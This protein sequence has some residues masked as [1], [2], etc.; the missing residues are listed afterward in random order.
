MKVLCV[1]DSH[2]S[3][4]SGFDAIQ[5]I[6]PLRSNN[7]YLQFETIHLGPILAYSLNKLSSK[8]LGREKLFQLIEERSSSENAILFCFGEI[9]CRYHLI[10]QSEIQHLPLEVIVQDCVKQYFSVIMEVRDRGFSTLVWNI[11]PPSNYA[12]SNPEFPHHGSF[13]RRQYATGLFNEMLKNHCES[14]GVPFLEANPLY[15]VFN[16]VH[17]KFF[18]DGLHLS[19]YVFP[20]FI[21]ALIRTIP[22]YGENRELKSIERLAKPKWVVLLG[23][24]KYYILKTW[25]ATKTKI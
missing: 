24:L 9:D 16:R 14:C 18:F 20:Y 17:P 3:L 22:K 2:S 4:F 25:R 10:R 23:L 8:H 19:Q 1:G 21:K 7:R 5:P 13:E 15:T 6:F 12:F 11:P